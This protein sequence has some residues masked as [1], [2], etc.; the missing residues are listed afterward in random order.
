MNSVKIEVKVG[1][2]TF[3]LQVDEPPTKF[4]R[5]GE[6]LGSIPGA[7][8]VVAQML[9]QAEGDTAS[10]IATNLERVQTQRQHNTDINR[11]YGD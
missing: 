7:W 3:T 8:M 4:T 11:G 2:Q 5:P 9:R 10:W 1:N 6:S